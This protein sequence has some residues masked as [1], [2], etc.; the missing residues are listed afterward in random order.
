MKYSLIHISARLFAFLYNL[1]YSYF[2]FVNNPMPDILK[3]GY[4]EYSDGFFNFSNLDANIVRNSG[5][6][7]IISIIMLT[8]KI[9]NL[10]INNS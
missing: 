1:K 5:I 2:A 4:Q 3:P 8:L 6:P 9:V 10:L 7:I